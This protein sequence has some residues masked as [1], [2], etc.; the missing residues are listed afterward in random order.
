[1]KQQNQIN[2]LM[3]RCGALEARC[4]ALEY[5]NRERD[6]PTAQSSADVG[7]RVSLP[8]EIETMTNSEPNPKPDIPEGWY[9][10]HVMFG[11]HRIVDPDGAHFYAVPALN[12]KKPVPFAT[13]DDAQLAL[14]V[15]T[16]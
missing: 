5:A 14:E 12:G 8:D 16:S 11:R 13:K 6:D 7:G 15:L 3:E 10:E 2:A 1:M 4:G 9:I